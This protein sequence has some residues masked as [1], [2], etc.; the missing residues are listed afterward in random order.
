MSEKNEVTLC[1]MLWNP[2]CPKL[3]LEKDNSFSIRDDYDSSIKLSA[4]EMKS[5]ISKINEL[6]ILPGDSL[7]NQRQFDIKTNKRLLKK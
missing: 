6:N 3:K 1:C 4:D 2:C 5:V 7:D